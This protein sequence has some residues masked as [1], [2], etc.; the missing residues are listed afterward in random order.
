MNYSQIRKYDVANGLGIRTSIFFCGC[1]HKCAGCFNH[2]L[3]DFKSGQLFDDNAKKLLFEY[4]SDEHVKGLS[5]LG[6]E[7][8]QQD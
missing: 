7:P 6:G 8:L 1:T 2:E 5:V 3:W 4:L